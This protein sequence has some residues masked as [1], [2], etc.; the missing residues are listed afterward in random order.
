MITLWWP[1]HKYIYLHDYTGHNLA[2]DCVAL[3]WANCSF[4]YQELVDTMWV[5]QCAQVSPV[6]Y[7]TRK[8][9]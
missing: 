1:G 6:Y 9:C 2:C 3:V 4:I 7:A 5:E 8:C